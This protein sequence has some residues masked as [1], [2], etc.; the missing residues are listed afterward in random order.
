MG[1]KPPTRD[2][3]TSYVDTLVRECREKEA[4]ARSMGGV[5]TSLYIGGGTPTVLPDDLLARLLN[6]VGECFGTVFEY[7][8]EA[9]RPDTL[10]A[11]KLRLLRNHNVNR[12]AVNPQTLNDETLVKIGRNHTVADFYRAF[13]LARDTGFD[14]INTDLIAGLPGEGFDD[15]YKSLEA[16][17]PLKPENITLHA[18]SVKRA[19]KMNEDRINEGNSAVTRTTGAGGDLLRGDSGGIL[20]RAGYSPYYLYR[21]KNTIDL[22]ENIGYSQPG[23]ECL[24]NIGMMSEVQTILGIGAGAVSKYVSGMKISRVFNEKNPEIYIQRKG[25]T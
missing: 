24:Y 11:E 22:S 9:G 25:I 3:L 6:A 16:L 17:L 5:V 20:T 19:S 23:Y 4:E 18:L 7:T 21:Q 15:L 14:C 8:V 2:L 1:H 13:S 12:I 10:T